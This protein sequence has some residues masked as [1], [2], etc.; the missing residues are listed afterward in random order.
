V[1]L[2]VADARDG[3]LSGSTLR[4]ACSWGKVGTAKEQMVYGEVTTLLPLIVSDAY[5]RGHWKARKGRRL[6]DLFAGTPARA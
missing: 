2:T 6:A 4:E 1:Q 3:A 5:H